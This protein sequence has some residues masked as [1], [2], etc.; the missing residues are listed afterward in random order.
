MNQQP[1]DI[2]LVE[3]NF[4]HADLVRQSLADL[5]IANRIFHV[6]DGEAALDYLHHRGE[7]A[8]GRISPRPDLILLDLR[9]PKIDGLE[10]LRQIKES[11]TLRQIPVVVL[12]TSDGGPDVSLAYDRHANSYLV[13]PIDFS[14]FSRLM[15]DLGSYWLGWNRVPDVKPPGDLT[16]G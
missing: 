4:D 13:K 1:L 5:S 16:P 7:F 8:E 6:A 2:L 3:D 15:S 14:Q 9:L 12:T 10:V 11:G